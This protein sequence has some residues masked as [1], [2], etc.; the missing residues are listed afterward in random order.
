VKICCVIHIKL[1]TVCTRPAVYTVHMYTAHV[2]ARTRPCTRVYVAVYTTVYTAVYGPCT[3]VHGVYGGR[4][5][6]RIHVYAGYMA[7][8]HAVHGR[9]HVYRT[10]YVAVYTA[11]FTA[12]M[13]T[14]RTRPAVYAACTQPFI[15]SC[16]RIHGPYSKRI[17]CATF[18]QTVVVTPVNKAKHH[19][20]CHPKVV[21]YGV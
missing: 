5:H 10:V 3:R 7:R 6:D 9:V 1:F 8:V 13:F 2:H 19:I 4:V 18:S 20:A 12:C 16:T 11:V 15:R 21:K 14:A 17:E